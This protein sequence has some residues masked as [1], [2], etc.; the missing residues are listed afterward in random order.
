M[1]MHA[2]SPLRNERETAVLLGISAKTL[3][4]WRWVG[5]G[6]RYHKVGAAVRYSDADIELFLDNAKRG[7]TSQAPLRVVPR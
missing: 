1:A 7:S 4:R 6:P 2:L 3:R 5:K